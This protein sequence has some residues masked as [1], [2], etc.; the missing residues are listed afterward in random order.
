MRFCFIIEKE[1]RNNP[2]PRVVAD[3]LVQWGNIVDILEPQETV[4]C[5][6]NMHL[7]G[8][9]A[10]VLKTVAGGPGLSILEAAEAAGIATI[11]K[12]RS[13]RLVRN[14]AV[15]AT[16]ALAH[17]L[18]MPLTYFV[19]HLDL[20]KQIP[21]EI[22]PIVVKP[23]NGSSCRDIYR[24]NS[25][26]DLDALAMA[27]KNENFFLAQRYM[28]NTGFDIKA[29]VIGREV[30]AVAK[31]SPLHGNITEK[32][33]PLTPEIRKLALD[34]GRIFGL[35]I[36]GIDLVETPQGLVM[37]DINDFPS[38]GHV[39]GA[40]RR[41]AEY[42]LHAVGRVESK[43]LVRSEHRKRRRQTTLKKTLQIAT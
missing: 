35:D 19:T 5:L 18:P 14:K 29:Y 43:S 42:I 41:V 11:N 6:S 26:V 9:D 38:F 39:P 25:P 30:Y 23:N 17:G 33:I 15:A 32:L 8:Y 21:L 16:Y 27:K 31:K 36:Y 12:T 28:E 34:T 1:Y 2:M 20:L 7:Q 24:V 4:I 37:L 3:Q 10:Y 22:Y 13:I 40:V